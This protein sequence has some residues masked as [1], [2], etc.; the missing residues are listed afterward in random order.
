VAHPAG[1]RS[2][3]VLMAATILRRELDSG[4]LSAIDLTSRRCPWD[5]VGGV[6]LRRSRPNRTITPLP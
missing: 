5:R 6:S 3:L 2:L 1:V 4:K